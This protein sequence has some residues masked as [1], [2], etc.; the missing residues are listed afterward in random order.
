MD[1]TKTLMNEHQLI[2]E[3]ITLLDDYAGFVSTNPSDALL[4]KGH[5]FVDF[6][7]TFAD[8]YHHA[9][10]ENIL[11]RHL[12][13]DGVLTHCNPLPQMLHEHDEGRR[14]V[15]EMRAALDLSDQSAFVKAAVYYA[16]LLKDHINKEDNILY[17]MA[18]DGLSDEQ[19]SDILREYDVVESHM[20]S[21][22]F[23][24]DYTEQ[25]QVLQDYLSSLKTAA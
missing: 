5:L 17:Q 16:T 21:A 22:K 2:L 3:Y 9:K 4:K 14:A 20:D 23:W 24:S 12:E 15:K 18:E 6:I 25:L 8:R 13:G 10:E 19:K 1:V 11:F 7:A